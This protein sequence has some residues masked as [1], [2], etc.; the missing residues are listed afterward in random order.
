MIA[1]V[2]LMHSRLKVLQHF[3]DFTAPRDDPELSRLWSW[4]HALLSRP[5]VTKTL[6]YEHNPVPFLEVCALR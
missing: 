6:L 4:E 2:A 1:R 5:S 3:C